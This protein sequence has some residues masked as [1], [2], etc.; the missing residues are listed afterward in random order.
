MLTLEQ[1]YFMRVSERWLKHFV[2]ASPL[3]LTLFFNAVFWSLWLGLGMLKCTFRAEEY[4]PSLH[5]VF[6][7]IPLGFCVLVQGYIREK[8]SPIT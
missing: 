2:V 6:L 3:S 1:S 7:L 8:E 5:V 4:F